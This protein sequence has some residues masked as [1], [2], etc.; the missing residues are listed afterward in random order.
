MSEGEVQTEWTSEPQAE[1]LPRRKAVTVVKGAPRLK[2]VNRQQLVFRAV[3]VE[4]LI[5]DIF[6]K[7]VANF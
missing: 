2:V 7:S 4:Q 6:N 3:D 1:P 5:E